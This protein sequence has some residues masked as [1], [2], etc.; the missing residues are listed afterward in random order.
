[1]TLHNL[2][3][4]EFESRKNCRVPLLLAAP[5]YVPAPQ[6]AVVLSTPLTTDRRALDVQEQT[7][8]PGVL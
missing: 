5:L 6:G 2:E 4:V 7:G 8:L 1:M 3:V